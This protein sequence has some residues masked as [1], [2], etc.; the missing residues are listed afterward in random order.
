MRE[1]FLCTVWDGNKQEWV[2]CGIY[3]TRS[4]AREAGSEYVIQV[5]G[6]VKLLDWDDCDGINFDWYQDDAGVS[7]TRKIER[8]LLDHNPW[9]E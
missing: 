4:K 7:Y 2:S 6:D 3:S 9:V 1:L 8:F 5:G